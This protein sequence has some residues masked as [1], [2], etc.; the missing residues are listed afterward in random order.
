MQ[1]TELRNKSWLGESNCILASFTGARRRLWLISSQQWSIR[2]KRLSS[3]F[4]FWNA[5]LRWVTKLALPEPLFRI[6]F[7]SELALEEHSL[8]R[9]NFRENVFEAHDAPHVPPFRIDSLSQQATQ[10]EYLANSYE[11]MIDF[12]VY[13][14]GQYVKSASVSTVMLLMQYYRHDRKRFLI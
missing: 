10:A 13:I 3:F 5:F 8:T 12:N 7:C 6:R 11:M 2:S 4:Y 9:K 14:G 1:G